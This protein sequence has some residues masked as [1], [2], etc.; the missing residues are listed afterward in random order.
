MPTHSTRDEIR[1]R[2]VARYEALGFAPRIS[3]Q[4]TVASRA[5]SRVNAA[6]A[7]SLAEG[8]GPVLFVE[9]DTI[10]SPRLPEW[11]ETLA[12]TLAPVEFVLLFSQPRFIP[13]AERS[14]EAR[15]EERGLGPGPSR[16]V[17]VRTFD[18]FSGSQAILFSRGM[19]E[20]LLAAPAVTVETASDRP[21]DWSLP[22][23]AR[24]AGARIRATI[25]SVVEHES[26]PSVV[27]RRRQAPLLAWR[28]DPEAAPP[29]AHTLE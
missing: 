24:S 17:E 11:I 3:R 12:P 18:S 14:V 20:A 25:P 10:P 27:Q 19:V 2:T 29:E 15:R 23:V 28:F 9:D 8:D 1:E 7:L 16:V 5:R 26:P 4:N 6:R 21:F 13:R 22:H